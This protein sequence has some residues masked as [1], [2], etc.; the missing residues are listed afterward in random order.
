MSKN[1]RVATIVY[2]DGASATSSRSL[3]IEVV[4]ASFFMVACWDTARKNK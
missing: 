2:R 1:M 3:M 4:A